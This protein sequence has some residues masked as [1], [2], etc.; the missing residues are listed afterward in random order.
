MPEGM[1]GRSDLFHCF[2]VIE[3]S[4]TI[5]STAKPVTINLAKKFFKFL[6]LTFKTN[7]TRP[8]LA[9]CACFAVL[10]IQIRAVGTIRITKYK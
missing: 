9:T 2:S 10:H 8:L 7:M 1:R 6:R 3:I 4:N 5:T